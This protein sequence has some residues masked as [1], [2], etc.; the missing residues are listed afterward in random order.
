MVPK[1]TFLSLSL[2]AKHNNKIVF[3]FACGCTWPELLVETT[4]RVDYKACIGWLG[5]A[6]LRV[7]QSKTERLFFKEAREG[8][9]PHAHLPTDPV[10][11]VDYRVPGAATLRYLGFFFDSKLTWTMWTSSATERVPLSRHYS[12][13]ETPSKDRAHIRV[14]ALVYRHRSR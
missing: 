10:L 7:E 14:P 4:M 3:I 1:K 2:W 6:S 13:S 8:G 9:T 5:K 11:N 12:F